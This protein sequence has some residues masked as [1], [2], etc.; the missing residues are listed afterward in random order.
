MERRS[1]AVF[2]PGSQWARPATKKQAFAFARD[3]GGYVMS[4]SYQSGKTAWDA[5]T[6]RAVGRLEA[7]FRK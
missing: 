4:I 3:H 7:D 1:W 2:L 5:P 6:F